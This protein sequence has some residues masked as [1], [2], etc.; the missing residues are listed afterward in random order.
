MTYLIGLGSP[1]FVGIAVLAGCGAAV[2]C[3]SEYG[4]LRYTWAVYS[5][6][7][8]SSGTGTIDRAPCMV[9]PMYGNGS[10]G[11]PSSLGSL[12]LLNGLAFDWSPLPTPTSRVFPSGLTAT[13][14]GYQPV[15]MNPLTADLRGAS[16][17]MTATQLLSALATYRV[18]P[19]GL[20]ARASG[21][22][23]SGAFGNRAVEIVS[24]TCPRFVSMTLTALLD[25]QA[26][27]S[28]PSLCRAI[29]LG[30][31]PTGTFR[32]TRNS[33]GSITS[34]CR[35]AQSET[36]SWCPLGPSTTSYGRPPST[37]VF[38]VPSFNET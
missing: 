17:S 8:L 3:S 10:R 28:R 15:G 1:T 9:V 12:F 35:P 32:T 5:L 6:S 14:V 24:T 37:T 16:T 20:R 13:A 27:N 21:V 11:T 23:P 2:S 30:C 31:S 4:Q 7:C 25:A 34:T 38:V 26:T 33:A 22:L 36:K 18:S 19:S 29:W